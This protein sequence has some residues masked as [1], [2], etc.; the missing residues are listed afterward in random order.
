MNKYIKKL[1]QKATFTQIGLSGYL[2]PVQ[3]KNFEIYF[4]KVKRGH[5]TFIISKKCSHIYFVLTGK[6]YFIIDNKKINVK[7]GMLVD[8]PSKVEYTYAGTMDLLLII[9]PPWFKENEIITR[10]N[11]WAE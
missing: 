1:P 5:D 6:G 9:T 3:N 7:A 11:S 4:I 2:F 10:K 8:V